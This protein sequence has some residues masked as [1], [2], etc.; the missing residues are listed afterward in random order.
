MKKTTEQPEKQEQANVAPP[1]TRRLSLGTWVT[2]SLLILL[3]LLLAVAAFLFLRSKQSAPRPGNPEPVETDAS[4]YFQY[5][6][7]R[8]PVLEDV[9]VNAYTADQ[10]YRDDTG[11]IRCTLENARYGIDVSSH[12]KEIDWAAV[13][14]DG[15]DFAII[16]VGY[17][18]YT[19]GS[20]QID[21]NFTANITGALENGLDVGVYFFSQAISEA[22]ALEE[23]EFVLSAIADYDIT[24]PVLFD[25]EQ[26]RNQNSRSQ[27]IDPNLLTACA[28]TFCEAIR[29][30][31][32]R[33][34]VYA[35]QHLAYFS[36]D[37]SALTDYV[38]WIAEYDD[39]PDFY[40]GFTLWQYTSRG[41]VAGIEPHVDRN[42]S[43]VD[44]GR[45]IRHSG[46][47]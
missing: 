26:I 5:G 41:T 29:S 11:A 19:A 13:A 45:T 1:K 4:R 31:G 46:R 22:E 12:Q 2:V 14:G 35:Y 17:R 7:H 23:A 34:G 3:A 40:Y 42:I 38:L 16:R 21:P 44:Y 30:A 36:Y 8:L 24:Y 9:P 15:I 32:Y 47:A 28:V 18:G 33:P 39:Y 20:V 43:F 37:L 10:F 25:W 27:T 6:E